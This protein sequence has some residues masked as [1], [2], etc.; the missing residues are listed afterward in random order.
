MAVVK[1]LKMLGILVGV[2]ILGTLGYQVV[3]PNYT[4]LDSIY[5]TVITVTTIGYKEVK[6]LTDAGRVFNILLILIGWFGF[7][8]V[9]RIGGQM[10][11]EGQLLKI[12]GRHRMDKKLASL[13]D[14]F[15]VCGYGRVGMIV[16]DEL[17][18]HKVRF[19]VIEKNPELIEEL[20]AKKYIYHEGDCTSDESLLS[21]GIK[22][23]KGLINAVADEADAVYITLSARSHNPDIFIMARADSSAAEQK[24]KRAGADRVISPHIAA[25]SRMAMSAVRPNVVDFMS[26]ESGDGLGIRIEEVEVSESSRL[27]GKSLKEMEVRARY[28]LNIIGMKKTDGRMIYNPSADQ[29]IDGNDTLFMVGDIDQLSKIDELLAPT[30]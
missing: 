4:F 16:C 10:I 20:I 29:I 27:V 2:L 23:A 12:L 11:I 8:M 22:G 28:G 19:A 14:H 25:G 13:S 5:M 24:L 3:Q 26:I 30:E 21:A 17:H 6:P 18:R 9:A 1:I 7:F 15:I